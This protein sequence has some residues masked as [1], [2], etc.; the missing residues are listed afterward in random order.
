MNE[1]KN[2]VRTI[3]ER[4]QWNHL[5][6]GLHCVVAENAESSLVGA[7]EC[8]LWRQHDWCITHTACE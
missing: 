8:K 3:E 4:S 1:R 7:G 2:A 6:E 5:Q